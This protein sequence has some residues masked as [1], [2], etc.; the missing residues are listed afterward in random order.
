MTEERLELVPRDRNR[1][2]FIMSPL[3][4]LPAEADPVLEEE[5]GKKNLGRPRGSSG[6]K[7]VFTLLTEVVAVYVGHSAIY[8]RGM[9]L[10]LPLG[11]LGDDGSWDKSG[12]GSRNGNGSSS[13]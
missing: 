12:S 11:Y 9:S 5:R 10:Q 13:L 7:V 4:L 6:T 3:V 8:V 2:L 1:N